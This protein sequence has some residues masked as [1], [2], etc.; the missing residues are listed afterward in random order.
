VI[1]LD[2]P[3]HFITLSNLQYPYYFSRRCIKCSNCNDTIMVP[4]YPIAWL[5]YILKLKPEAIISIFN[6]K[7]DELWYQIWN[8]ILPKCCNKPNRQWEFYTWTTNDVNKYEK[9]IISK[10]VANFL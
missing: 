1:S 3:S 8:R 2:Y 7:E 9:Y 5:E 4:S 6:I 10:A